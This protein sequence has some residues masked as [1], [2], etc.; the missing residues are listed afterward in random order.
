MGNPPQYR[1]AFIALVQPKERTASFARPG[2][3]PDAGDDAPPAAVVIP[4][5]AFA[6]AAA[7]PASPPAALTSPA[8][9]L[10]LALHGDG[11]LA[12]LAAAVQVL[13]LQGEQLAE[14]A[15]ADTLEIAFQIARRIVEAELRVGPEAFFSLIR[16]AL[17]RCGEARRVTIRVCPR[18]LSLLEGAQGAAAL[19]AMTVARVDL[20]SDI[21]LHPGDCVI[22]SDEARVD[23]RL[24]A[25]FGELR[26]ALDPDAAPRPELEQAS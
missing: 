22:E 12:T 16:S 25:R 13:R 8:G 23:G 2:A 20:V 19:Q 6:S 15:R 7:A 24:D 4:L 10:A 21:A 18:D 9:A 14:R 11:G 26:H 1:P 5:A 17:R 3:A